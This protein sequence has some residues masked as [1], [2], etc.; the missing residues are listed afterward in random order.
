MRPAFSMARLGMWS[1]VPPRGVGVSPSLLVACRLCISRLHVDRTYYSPIPPFF[2]AKW[3]ISLHTFPS[4][5][6]CRG[7]KQGV[8][9]SRITVRGSALR[10]LSLVV[11]FLLARQWLIC[12]PVSADCVSGNA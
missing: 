3:G 6:R 9:L 7:L 11:R 2:V 5:K 12:S 1:V 8:R 10:A 4:T